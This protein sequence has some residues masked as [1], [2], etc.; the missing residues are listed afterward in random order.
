MR[1]RRGIV[2]YILWALYGLAV[3]AALT[4]QIRTTGL[5]FLW[6]ETLWYLPAAAGC[7]LLLFAAVFLPA[8]LISRKAAGR[9]FADKKRKEPGREK[10]RRRYEQLYVVFLIAASMALRLGS[11]EAASRQWTEMCRGRRYPPASPL[12]R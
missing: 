12:L 6:E 9:A 2:S 4:L 7:V 3:C 5:F 1:F 11:M 10:K 8:R